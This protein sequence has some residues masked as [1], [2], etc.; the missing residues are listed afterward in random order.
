MVI[1]RF[2]GTKYEFL[3]N[4]YAHPF[5][6]DGKIYPTAEHAFQAMKATNEHDRQLIADAETPGKAKRL[7][8]KI[9]LRSDWED[10]KYTVMLDI[11]RAKFAIPELGQMLIDTWPADLIEG[12]TWHDNTWGN[13]SCDRCKNIEGKNYL[14]QILMS[15]RQ[16][17][18]QLSPDK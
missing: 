2:D 12:T 6:F 17:L 8:R 16:D 4:F 15:V 5:M 18:I 7:G 10:I 11:V 14:G 9:T 13:C 1:D 3:S